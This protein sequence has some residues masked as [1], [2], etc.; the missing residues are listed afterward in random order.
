MTPAYIVVEGD[1]DREII[2]RALAASFPDASARF[3]VVAAG[4]RSR[5]ASRARTL[6]MTHEGSV[7]VVVDADVSAPSEVRSELET[8]EALLSLAGDRRRWSVHLFVPTIED[9]LRRDPQIA[10]MLGDRIAAVSNKNEFWE[11]ARALGPKLGEA[12]SRLPALADLIRSLSP[13]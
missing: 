6:L 10:A 9:A 1:T 12:A 2:E 11:Q 8:L 5:A 3:R 13:A 4:G 7:H